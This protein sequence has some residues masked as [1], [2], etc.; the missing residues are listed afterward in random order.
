MRPS[1]R[2]V[3]Q[4][5]SR[6]ARSSAG[7]RRISPRMSPHASSAVGYGN[8]AVPHTSRP[9]SAAAFM[10]MEALRMPAVMRSLSLGRRSRSV[11]GNGV[12]SRMAMTMFLLG[13]GLQ[14][15]WRSPWKRHALLAGAVLLIARTGAAGWVTA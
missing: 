8:P 1:P 5:P 6:V 4:R 2:V 14:I 13:A 11:R 9:R 12:R 7:T 15:V 10:S 3:C